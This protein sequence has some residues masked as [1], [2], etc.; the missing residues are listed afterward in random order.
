MSES[1]TYIFVFFIL[2][3]ALPI[4][5]L[6]LGSILRPK[7]PNRSKET[8]YESGI[9]PIGPGWIQFNVKYYLFA[10]LFVIFDVETVFLYP[11][12]VVYKTL[13]DDIG[14]FVLVEMVFFLFFLLIGLIYA[15]KKK[16]LEWE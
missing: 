8:T 15:W 5:A 6:S 14:L 9:D 16:V 10:L 4:V 11:W 12:A 1:V 13:R 7:N 2:A 3:T